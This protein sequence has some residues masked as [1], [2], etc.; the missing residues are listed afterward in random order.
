MA[1]T[2]WLFFIVYKIYTK[3][4]LYTE[5]C[6]INWTLEKVHFIGTKNSS[7][8]IS[9]HLSP[10]ITIIT[11]H[12]FSFYSNDGRSI[13]IYRWVQ[14]LFPHHS[15]HVQSYIMKMNCTSFGDD[16]SKM[17]AKYLR[18]H[19]DDV[20]NKT[21]EKCLQKYIKAIFFCMISSLIS[22]NRMKCT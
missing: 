4:I 15:R 14:S 7:T 21:E 16:T 9:S 2:F 3:F 5:L 20:K 13:Y 10:S 17:N 22:G 1:L 18:I 11:C 8:R 19:V 6:L 12:L